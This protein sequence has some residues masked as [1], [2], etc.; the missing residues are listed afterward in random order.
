MTGGYQ[1]CLVAYIGNV[2]TREARCLTG[3]EVYIHSLD[4]LDGF[5]VY[6]EDL[7]TL[8]EVGQVNVNLTIETS[9]SQQGGV[10]HI[11]TVGGCKDDDTTIGAEAVHLSEQ[12]IQRVLA[13]VVATHGGILG[14]GAS[15]GINLI[16]EDDAGCFLL[17]LME[18]V[19]YTTCSHTDKHFDKVTTAHREERHTGFTG[20][21]LCQEGFTCTR[22]TYQQGSLRN[23]TT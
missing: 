20:N 5:Q 18:Y 1:G 10:E 19:A 4:E 21:S 17:G 23:L 16:D 13:L 8:G 7:F 3:Q 2:C 9:G 22:R 14:T 12:G 15:H 6:H 11:Y